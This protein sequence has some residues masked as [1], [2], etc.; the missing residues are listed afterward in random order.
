M[1]SREMLAHPK[2]TLQDGRGSCWG[3]E[4]GHKEPGTDATTWPSQEASAPWEHYV[5]F[6]SDHPP[7]KFY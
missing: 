7:A 1:S 6:L 5:E 2:K 4:I 3:Q